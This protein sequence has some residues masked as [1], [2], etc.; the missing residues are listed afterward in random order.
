MSVETNFWRGGVGEVGDRFRHVAIGT[1][2]RN[3]S[4]VK[5]WINL[6]AYL[7][8]TKTKTKIQ[9]NSSDDITDK[10]LIFIFYTF[11]SNFNLCPFPSPKIIFF[12]SSPHETYLD[13]PN[14]IY[15]TPSSPKSFR[16]HN[17]FS[18]P[19]EKESDTESS[20]H[21]LLIRYSICCSLLFLS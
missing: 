21:F 2:H 12:F 10:V 11:R 9:R 1:P 17:S 5:R 6:A 7:T 16:E 20:D 14:L 19:W 8:L 3:K 15:I 13:N 18:W 4:A